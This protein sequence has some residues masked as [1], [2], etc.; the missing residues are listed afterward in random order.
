MTTIPASMV[1]NETRSDAL[2][3]GGSLLVVLALYAIAAVVVQ[4]WRI[5]IVQPE[6]PPVAVM[7]DLAP[8]PKT[9]PALPVV[10]PPKPIVEP[11][12]PVERPKPVLRKPAPPKPITPPEPQAVPEPVAPPPPAAAA[13]ATPVAPPVAAA[14]AEP[15]PQVK[16]TYESLL[17]A[18]LER[19]KHY[20][21]VA[22]R[23]REQGTAALRFTMDRGGHVLAYKLE[24]SSGYNT[25][26]DEVLGMIKRA[27]PLPPIP[28]EFPAAQLELVVPIRFFL[29]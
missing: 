29:R 18:H 15:A 27:D 2:R 6:V 9:P 14:P 11:P 28:P 26:D 10:E 3:W 19:Y 22:Q 24:R 20:P 5:G 1:P 21:V 16:A 8:E 12:K 4:S 23:R 17:L 13:P 7:I 25:L